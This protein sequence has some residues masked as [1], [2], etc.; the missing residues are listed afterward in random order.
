MTI[1]ISDRYSGPSIRISDRAAE[2]EEVSGSYT[3]VIEV[4]PSRLNITGLGAL[5]ARARLNGAPVV[6]VEVAL[7]SSD[8]AVVP[9]P[10]SILTSTDGNAL[11]N[12]TALALGSATLSASISP[13]VDGEPILVE[14][15]DVVVVVADGQ[16]D[17]NYDATGYGSIRITLESPLANALYPQ[18]VRLSDADQ[19]RLFPGDTGLKRVARY[20]SLQ[21][22]FMPAWMR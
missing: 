20:E 12:F 21:V 15:D 9:L 3:L 8:P 18:V 14:A 16:A 7:S 17:D 6:G 1:N 22:T 10:A 4:A 13:I 2:T 5:V 11:T 19:Q